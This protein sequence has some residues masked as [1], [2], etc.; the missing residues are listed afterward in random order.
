MVA[1]GIDIGGTSIKGSLVNDKGQV[2]EVYNIPIIKGQDQN[3]TINRLIEAT[4]EYISNLPNKDEIAGIGL[5]I[6]GSIDSV[7]GVVTFSNNLE[8]EDLHVI[9]MFKKHFDLPIKITNDANA[10]ALGEAIFGAGRTNKD[11]IMITLGTGVGTGIIY[12]GK[13]Y[14]GMH[15]KGAEFGHSSLYLDGIP[16]NCGRRGCVEA[17]CSATALTRQVKEAMEQDKSSLLWEEAEK[18]GKVSGRI[19]FEAE[20]RGDETAKKVL[21][22]YIMYLGEA[23]LNICNIFRPDAI[24]L[25]GGI[26]NQGENLTSRL[27]KYCEKYEYGYPRSEATVIKTAELGY[28]SGIIGAACLILSN[29]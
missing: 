8:W 19:V 18:L 24:V 3:T 20:K 16:C 4:K 10:A 17:Y 15:G 27:V 6:P 9:E 2:G 7:A 1:I 26:A 5:G 12:D 29:K 21:D 13:I 28:N 23:M 11:V 14:E 25:S 22:Q